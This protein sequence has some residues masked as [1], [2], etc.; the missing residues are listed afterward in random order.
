ML[1]ASA[2]SPA[3]EF[4]GQAHGCYGYAFGLR[5]PALIFVVRVRPVAPARLVAADAVLSRVLG[6]PPQSGAAPDSDAA[7]E[8]V[9]H[10]SRTLLENNGHP[11]FSRPRIL[12]RAKDAPDL[13]RVAYPCLQHKAAVGA[14][15]FVIT[16]LDR[17]LADP[18]ADTK[19][20]NEF[21]HVESERIRQWLSRSG[22]QGFNTVHFLRAADELGIPWLRLVGN[23]IQFGQ[24]ARARWLDSSFTDATPIISTQLARNKKNA[25]ILLR[26]AG[27]PVPEHFLA[28]SEEAAV[29]YAEELG[30][31]VVVKPADLDGGKAVAAHL[32]TAEAVRKAYTAARQAS[33]NVLVEKHVAGRDHRIQVVLGEVQGVLERTPGGVTGNGRDSV[34]VLLEAQ[35]EERRTATDDRR[36]LHAMQFD[37]EAEQLLAA[38]SMNWESVPGTGQVVRLRGAA[39]VTNGGVPVPIPPERVHP[40]NLALAR[41][42]ARTL[43]LDVAGIDM[44]IP[45]IGESWLQSGAYICEVNAQPQ[46]FTTMHRPMLQSLVSGDGRVPVVVF[47]DARRRPE[48]A[49]RVHRGLAAS[50]L[51]PGLAGREGVW[52]ASQRIA[53][54]GL[55]TFVGGRMLLQD[56]TVDAILLHV[57]DPGVLRQGWPVDRC[58]VL[59]FG[60]PPADE[61]AAEFPR[62]A[63]FSRGLSPQY[64]IVD[65]GVA[66]SLARAR[67]NFGRHRGLEILPAAKTA[68]AV[69]DKSIAAA[70]LK[71]LAL[72]GRPRPPRPE[73]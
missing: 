64:V 66:G 3:V 50:G 49:A 70:V 19:A 26:Q 55:G 62:L 73:P 8:F 61:I 35:N 31:P 71:R 48:V 65:G 37:E 54:P 15:R 39:N 36:Y 34:R 27:V 20:T 21:L 60:E 40:D 4:A 52:I 29:R 1:A 10:W 41:R 63:E 14:L 24:G 43:R 51:R 33:Q 28:G 72:P 23:V 42:A 69:Q 17:L 13:R 47:L 67:R 2:T 7:L 68:G 53:G 57:A 16:V 38:Q 9:L 18:A 45:D 32:V 30:Y 59:V 46:M 6:A 56:P 5:Q 25:A 11:L 58:D 22:V 44:L 12:A